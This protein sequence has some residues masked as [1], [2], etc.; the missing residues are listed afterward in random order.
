MPDVDV[1]LPPPIG[2]VANV[3]LMHTGTWDLSTGPATFTADDLASAVAALDCPA[4]RRPVLKLGHTPDPMPGQPAVGF[5]ANLATAED[6]RTLVGDYV[7]MPGWLVTAD[8]SGDSVL[9]SAYP[10]RSIEGVYNFRCQIG[11]THPFVVTAVALLGDERPGIG[12]LQSLQDLA[13]LYGVAAQVSPVGTPVTIPV[14][15]SEED[16][17]PAPPRLAQVTAGVTTEDVRRAFYASPGGAG[18][19]T[20]IEEM[21]LTPERQLIVVDDAS[22]TRSR[23]P[24][25]IGDGDGDSAVSFGAAVPVVVRYEDAPTATA[26]ASA[27]RFASRA[28]SRPGSAPTSPVPSIPV[29]P[30]QAA[31]RIHNAP[32]RGAGMDPAKLREALGLTPD[33]SDTEVTAALASA[34]LAPSSTPAAPAAGDPTT[35]PA[36]V[37]PPQVPA[38]TAGASDA[39]LLDPAQYNALRQQA[40]RGDEA[41]RKLRENEC[42]Q[43]LD[44]AIKAGKFPPARREHWKTLW[45]ADP[46]G[47]KATIDK[48]AANVIPVS[49]SGYPGVGDET[50]VDIVYGSMYPDMKVGA[51]RG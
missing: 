4:V 1:V 15:A 32:V 12:T 18:W 13:D 7:G 25:V 24:I 26:A 23:I 20:W 50:E 11:H 19:D 5:V 17:M 51:G 8:A 35:D 37:L 31:A 22:G 34:G 41:W 46:D 44:A 6:G 28:E 29:T 9:S 14:R 27:I 10:D 21:Q 45:A 47:T 42:E 36:P 16:R 38:V 2:R 39:V 48:L 49:A 30:A 40:Q 33:S 43:V 3:E